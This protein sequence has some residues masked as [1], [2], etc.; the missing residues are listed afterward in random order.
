MEE[1]I[2]EEVSAYHLQQVPV[3]SKS[4]ENEQHLSEGKDQTAVNHAAGYKR[5]IEGDV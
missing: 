5:R 1:T 4:A 2:K 3:V